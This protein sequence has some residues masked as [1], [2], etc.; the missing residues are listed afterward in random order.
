[1]LRRLTTLGAAIGA[2]L[3][4]SPASAQEAKQ[5]GDQGEFIFGADR[6]FSLFAYTQN[7]FT[8]SNTNNTATVTGTS[9]S[10]FGG[11]NSV[12]VGSNAVGGGLIAGNPTFYNVPRLGFDY[13]II[14]GLTLG[15]EVIAFFTLGGNTSVNNAPN[16]PNPGGNAFG[17]APRVGYIFPLSDVIAIWPRG[18]VSYY[19]ANYSA[20]NVTFNR[21]NNTANANVFGL[22]ID[23]V[24]TIAPVNHFA[25]MVGPTLDWGFAGGASTS[26]PQVPDCSRTTQQSFSYNAINFA[27][28]AGLLGWF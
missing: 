6:L 28:N 14:Q 19:D 4:A 22:D 21:C 3:V 7:Q 16:Q 25:F 5:F 23:P 2:L 18:G 20:Q 17:V 11:L 1:M 12:A 15:G 9:M 13:T 8:V 24:L 26:T 27:L 10:I